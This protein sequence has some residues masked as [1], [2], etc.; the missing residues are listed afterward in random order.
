MYQFDE[1]HYLEEIHN[2]IDDTY[3]QHYAQGKYQATDVILDAGYGE[4][5]CMGNML[6]YCKRYGKKEG[7]NRKDLLKVI[8]YAIIMLH[9]HDQKEEGR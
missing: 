8:H 7:R 4:G 9:I 3:S 1:E 5:F 2:Y 6:K